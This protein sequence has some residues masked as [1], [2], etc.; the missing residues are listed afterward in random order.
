MRI[1]QSAR[2][3]TRDRVL[4]TLGLEPRRSFIES[5]LSATGLLGAGILIGVGAALLLGSRGMTARGAIGGMATE[6]S[7]P[8]TQM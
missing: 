4:Q 8:L 7:R 3:V 2:N 5:A 6:G 1:S